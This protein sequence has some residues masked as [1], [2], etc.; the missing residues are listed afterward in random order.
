MRWGSKNAV[1]QPQRRVNNKNI[2]IL[3]RVKKDTHHTNLSSLFDV[4]Q[5]E[6]G[7]MGFALI[8][9]AIAN[10]LVRRMVNH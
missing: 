1:T 7:H 6:K 8:F 2:L 5:A 10:I 4:C 9:E 3:Q